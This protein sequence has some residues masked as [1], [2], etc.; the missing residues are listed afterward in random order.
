MS[1]FITLRARRFDALHDLLT[2]CQ[3]RHRY[4]LPSYLAED[5][6]LPTTASQADVV[7]PLGTLIRGAD[8]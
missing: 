5:V 4:A 8:R 3:W 7:D 2:G 6:G 1:E